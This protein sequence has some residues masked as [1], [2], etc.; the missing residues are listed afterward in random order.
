M[1]LSSVLIAL[2][3]LLHVFFMVLEIFLWDK[4]LGMRIFGHRAEQA[5]VTKLLAMNQG[6]YNGFLAAGLIWALMIGD[7][8]GDNIAIFFLGCVIVAG[9]FGGMTVNRSII[10][11]QAL[12]AATAMAAVL[13]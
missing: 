2:V 3:A 6:L 5:R 4:P 8:G 13:L 11:V 7:N 9:L 10:L 1:A 12:P